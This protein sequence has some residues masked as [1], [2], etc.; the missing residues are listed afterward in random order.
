[1]QRLQRLQNSANYSQ[2]NGDS[3]P[4]YWFYN[5]FC[6]IPISCYASFDAFCSAMIIIFPFLQYR[7]NI[8]KMKSVMMLNKILFMSL[9]PNVEILKSVL[10]P[11]LSCCKWQ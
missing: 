10:L 8:E 7:T 2:K 4:F 5:R 1:M 11:Y 9:L 6:L 3:G